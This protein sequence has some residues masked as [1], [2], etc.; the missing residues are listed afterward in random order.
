MQVVPE[1][2]ANML[3]FCQSQGFELAFWL[4]LNT[5]EN[6]P[7]IG[8]GHGAITFPKILRQLTAAIM[9]LSGFTLQIR[10]F[11]QP[12]EL[13][14]GPLV[15]EIIHADSLASCSHGF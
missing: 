15:G 7:A 12:T 14:F 8:V 13:S 6:E 4:F 5:K 1:S 10:R 9:T 2:L 11:C 3:D